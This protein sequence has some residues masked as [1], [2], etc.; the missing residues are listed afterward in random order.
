MYITQNKS[1]GFVTL[2][3]GLNKIL[4]IHWIKIFGKQQTS[5]SKRISFNLL[6]CNYST[7][8]LLILWLIYWLFVVS[9]PF[10]IF[11]SYLDVTRTSEAHQT[12]GSRPLHGLDWSFWLHHK[13]IL[14]ILLCIFIFKRIYPQSEILTLLIKTLIQEKWMFN[15]I[16]IV[17]YISF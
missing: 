11:H 9:V 5:I 12:P 17:V 1:S 15:L 2:I 14:R 10:R 8:N 3:Y 13:H 16:N 7:K 4:Y 6:K